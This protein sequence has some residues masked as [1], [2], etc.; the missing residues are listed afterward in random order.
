MKC[1]PDDS[2]CLLNVLI[3]QGLQGPSWLELVGSIG[4]PL[5]LGLASIALAFATWLV[6]RESHRLNARL[7][8][9]AEDESKRITRNAIAAQL[10]NW[11]MYE[12]AGSKAEREAYKADRLAMRLLAISAPQRDVEALEELLTILTWLAERPKVYPISTEDTVRQAT[13][14]GIAIVTIESWSADP[15]HFVATSEHT[16]RIVTDAESEYVDLTGA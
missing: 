9:A 2:A 10:R 8:K 4:V 11:A 3:Q 6:S 16:R 1:D 15:Q 13:L 12:W 14:L 5:V 7:A